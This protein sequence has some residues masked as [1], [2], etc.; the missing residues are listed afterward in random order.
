M[1]AKQYWQGVGETEVD[2][3]FADDFV[4]I[5]SFLIQKC[6]LG[7]MGVGSTMSDSAGGWTKPRIATGAGAVG[8]IIGAFLPWISLFNISGIEGDGVIT[9]AVGII[10]A[11]VIIWKWTKATQIVSIVCGLLIAGVGAYYVTEPFAAIGI[12]V[13]A[14]AGVAVLIGGI[15]GLVSD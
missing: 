3:R 8:A 9:L 11:P 15:L 10:V 5:A 6:G 13:T 7:D 1:S 14:L 4:K 12:Y 2:S